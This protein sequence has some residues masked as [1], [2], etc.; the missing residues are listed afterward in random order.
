[1]FASQ[2]TLALQLETKMDVSENVIEQR[3][4]TSRRLDR[5]HGRAE[6]QPAKPKVLFLSISFD[7]EP[8]AVMGLPLARKLKDS[9]KYDVS[10]LTAIPWYPLGRRYPGYKLRAWQWEVLDGIK[11]L[12]V[13]LYP[14][15]DASFVR[16]VLTYVSFTTSAIV[17]GLPHVG[18]VDV[19]YYFDSLPTTGFVAFCLKLLRRA[20]T[21]QHIGDLWPD[22][23]LES[24]ML[25]RPLAGVV[26][27]VLGGWCKFLYRRHSAVTVASPGLKT[28]LV[29]RGV[30][31]DKVSVIYTWAFEDKFFPAP[32]DAAA[33][34]EMDAGG[35]FTVLY[36]GNLGPLQ[37]IDTVLDTAKLLSDVPDIRFVVIGGGQQESR[38]RERASQL[39]LRNVRFLGPR[40]LDQ[41]NRYNATADALLVHLKDIRLMRSTTPSKTQVAMASARPILMGVAG[42]AAD[43][44]RAADAGIAFEP[45]NP[46]AMADAILHLKSLSPERRREMGNAGRRFYE[47]EMS[48]DVGAAKAAKLIEESVRASKSSQRQTA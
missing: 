42:D 1:M 27:T 16:R 26:R 25:P 37:A 40:G 32:A 30:P 11:V 4:A 20:A 10:V 7:P 31:A 36:A 35:C 17:F 2:K 43:V 28:M 9:G 22:T 47:T 44:V 24:G 39:Q 18:P 38:L 33:A 34:D 23:V 45:E 46:R 19:V 12:R 48:L 5:S 13:P 6:S 15:H 29:E 21:V 14:S 3:P 8:G 41:M